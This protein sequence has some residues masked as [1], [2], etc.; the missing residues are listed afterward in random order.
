MRDLLNNPTLPALDHNVGV[1]P[2]YLYGND[3]LNW[4]CDF[5][6]HIKI[7]VGLCSINCL[8]KR[9]NQSAID[10]SREWLYS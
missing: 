4:K 6:F 10:K 2:P 7:M 1:E 8:I 5:Y 3:V 9:W